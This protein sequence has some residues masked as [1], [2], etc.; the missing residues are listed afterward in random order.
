M[1]RLISALAFA[2]LSLTPCIAQLRPQASFVETVAIDIA[3]G[4]LVNNYVVFPGAAPSLDS[5]QTASVPIV[6]SVGGLA[7]G[8]QVHLNLTAS[9]GDPATG[10]PIIGY[11]FAVN[12]T[13]GPG[14]IIPISID[15]THAKPGA[16]QLQLTATDSVSNVSSAT[17]A[18][19]LLITTPAAGFK[20]MSANTR[21]TLSLTGT[22]ILV[23]AMASGEIGAPHGHY[24]MILHNLGTSTVQISSGNANFLLAPG[25]V[26]AADLSTQF[27][28]VATNYDGATGM[29][30]VG[31][32]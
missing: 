32:P 9:A 1:K 15:A 30:E 28:V 26:L 6:I 27:D 11:T 12:V 4:S 8:T 14:I 2:A 7:A 5:G 22:Q 24:R 13:A 18:R 20:S 21:M 23:K 25:D 19:G 16:Y 29:L 31:F 3:P 17:P 10:A